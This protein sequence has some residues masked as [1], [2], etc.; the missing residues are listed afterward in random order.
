MRQTVSIW[1]AVVVS[2][3]F[4]VWGYCTGYGVGKDVVRNEAIAVGAGQWCNSSGSRH[5]QWVRLGE[6]WA[7]IALIDDHGNRVALCEGGPYASLTDSDSVETPDPP[8]GPPDADG[9][10]QWSGVAL[11]EVRKRVSSGGL[12]RPPMLC[13]GYH[14]RTLSGKWTPPTGSLV[15]MLR[16]LAVTTYDVIK[17]MALRGFRFECGQHGDK[18]S[19]FYAC[20]YKDS[21]ATRCE[22]CDN[23]EL[24]WDDCGHATTLYRAT[25]MAAK[26]ALKQ[27]VSIPL[28]RHFSRPSRS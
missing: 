2:F 7:V 19:G 27:P 28:P 6:P 18:L 3:C 20:F 10:V 22:A 23:A 25:L 8:L 17:R 24:S 5:F 26:I 9:R 12:T 1:F 15:T 21:E 4:L 11:G 13:L 16:G 14:L